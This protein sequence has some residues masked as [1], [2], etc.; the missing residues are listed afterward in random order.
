MGLFLSSGIL[1][2]PPKLIY[3]SPKRP[4]P[5]AVPCSTPCG[6][7]VAS[8]CQ[9]VP[10]PDTSC[11]PWSARRGKCA[12]LFL[13]RRERSHALARPFFTGEA[14]MASTHH[15]A[16]PEHRGNC[17]GLPCLRYQPI[18]PATSFRHC[19]SI[20]D[21]SIGV[22]NEPR[23]ARRGARSIAPQPCMRL[24]PWRV[25]TMKQSYASAARLRGGGPIL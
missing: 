25:R 16:T 8:M 9:D 17:P 3:K 21:V 11:R 1:Q 15:F 24:D 2:L 6:E 12:A 5:N 19:N 20:S 22:A 13:A 23:G 14:S 10:R 4:I 7:H 18:I